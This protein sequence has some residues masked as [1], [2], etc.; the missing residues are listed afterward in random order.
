MGS[1]YAVF[2]GCNSMRSSYEVDEKHSALHFGKDWMSTLMACPIDHD[3]EIQKI[4]NQVKTY[5]VNGNSVSLFDSDKKEV[6]KLNRDFHLDGDYVLAGESL[7]WE[8]PNHQTVISFSGN[9]VSFKGCNTNSAT[10]QDWFH[11]V[12]FS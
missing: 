3:S 6:L 9:R 4:A 10:Y 12:K 5:K 8:R 1:G 11:K 2:H 7:K